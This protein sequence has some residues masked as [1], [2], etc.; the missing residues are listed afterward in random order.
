MKYQS[1]RIKAS[2]VLGLM[3]LTSLLFA[4][5]VKFM[6]ST[7]KKTYYEFENV[8][9]TLKI[10]NADYKKVEMPTF[11]D[12]ELIRHYVNSSSSHSIVIINGKRVSEGGDSYQ[13][14]FEL[15]PK[16]KGRLKLPSCKM[17]YDGKTYQAQ[18]F[19]VEVKALDVTQNDL[20]NDRFV[21]VEV[22][23]R[24]PYVGEPTTVTYTL[25]TVDQ[26]SEAAQLKKGTKIKNFGPIH[27]KELSQL[28]SSR[29]NMNGK[30]YTLLELHKTVL[31][32]VKGGEFIIP[33]QT[34]EYVSYKYYRESWFSTRKEEVPHAVSIP[35]VK[36]NIKSLPAAPADFSGLVGSYKIELKAD[37]KELPVNDALTAKYIVSGTGNSY[38]LKELELDWSPDWEVF[39]PK[40]ED[41]TSVGARGYQGKK[42]IEV[43]AIPR[44]P[45]NLSVPA[46]SMSYFD[47]ASKKYKQLAVEGLSVNV[48][49]E[50]GGAGPYITA[51]V[52]V[53]RQVDLSGVNEL[54]YLKTDIS[55][56]NDGWKGYFG[57]T[58]AVVVGGGITLASI[59]LFLFYVPKQQSEEELRNQRRSKAYKVAAKQLNQLEQQEIQNQTEF[60][61]ALESVFDTYLR[62]KLSIDQTELNR[63]VLKEKLHPLLGDEKEVEQVLKLQGQCNMA[64]YS[65]IGV[66]P[67]N[68]LQEI[69]S[70]INKIES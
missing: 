29:V 23:N 49:G 48:T 68:L 27:A 53:R 46:Y 8:R 41:G 43:V 58:T 5:E 19:S 20:S 45:G 69:Q 70:S 37:K 9:F 11:D 31:I 54:R 33:A 57:T 25:Y 55:T 24:N 16:K 34:L 62:D 2:A 44:Q 51:D 56:Y 61:A 10:E 63:V 64:R 18:G 12:F 26:I 66:N 14:I 35:A 21:K 7:D 32:P 65:P 30:V 36:L 67:K 15:K 17:E 22:S 4:G 38:A 3:L 60:F 28:S 47:L 6:S 52:P 13:V 39:E 40:I 50:A 42:V 59:L 1:S